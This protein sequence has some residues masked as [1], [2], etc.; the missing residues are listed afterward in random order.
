MTD[1]TPYLDNLHVR[2]PF[3]VEPAPSD[4]QLRHA[5]SV[6]NIYLNLARRASSWNPSLALY[7]LSCH[8][9]AYDEFTRL[10][11]LR[12]EYRNRLTWGVDGE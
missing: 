12:L 8:K 1:L 2:N 4:V 11:L 9:D 6:A 7:S 3:V 10:L 5:D